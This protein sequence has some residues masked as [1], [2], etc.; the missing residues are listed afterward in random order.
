M[1]LI[2]ASECA[3]CRLSSVTLAISSVTSGRKALS[4]RWQCT[5]FGSQ[6]AICIFQLRFP[7]RI[8]STYLAPGS[9]FDV[10]HRRQEGLTGREAAG[11][12][13][14]SSKRLVVECT[15]F[16]HAR[17]DGQRTTCRVGHQTTN[18]V[19]V[20]KCLLTFVETFGIMCSPH[21]SQLA[22]SEQG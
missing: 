12:A 4:L 13:R 14:C 5:R 11:T 2:G 8:S 9:K 18:N 20:C 1:N 10:A 19:P 7:R 17:L 21:N 22:T 3:C 15:A 6:S 16:L